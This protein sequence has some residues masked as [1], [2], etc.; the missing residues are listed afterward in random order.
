MLPKL[1]TDILISTE[2][3]LK[4]ERLADYKSEFVEGILYAMSGA[5]EKHNLIVFNLITEI[6]RQIKKRPCKAYANDMK[7]RV[8]ETNYVYP[9][10]SALC[11]EAKFSDEETD[12]LLNPSIIIEVLSESTSNYDRGKKF[13]L[14]R[15]LD[16]LQEYILVDQDRCYIEYHVKKGMQWILTELDNLQDKLTLVSIE[17]EI[18]VEDI[19]NRVL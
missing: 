10:V 8:K 14:Y 11:G 3:Y 2:E 4:K 19:Y 18:L 5:S 12:V 17:C 15:R 9:D 13:E 1:R 6:G 7:I 16:S